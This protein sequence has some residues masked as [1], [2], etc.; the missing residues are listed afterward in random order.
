M[1][2]LWATRLGE[3]DPMALA[4]DRHHGSRFT[5][6]DVPAGRSV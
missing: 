6:D 5:G 4:G 1:V 3:V 2:V